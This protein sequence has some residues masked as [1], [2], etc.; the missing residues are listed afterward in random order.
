M[1]E[2]EDIRK[3]IATPD[4]ANAFANLAKRIIESIQVDIS[5]EEFE[6]RKARHIEQMKLRKEELELDR[7]M[8]KKDSLLLEHRSSEYN[9]DDEHVQ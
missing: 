2:M 1:M 6:D 9:N 8:L 4:E 3:G 7:L 5:K